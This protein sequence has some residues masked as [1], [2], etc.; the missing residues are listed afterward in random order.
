MSFEESCATLIPSLLATETSAHR[1][2]EENARKVFDLY[3]VDENKDVLQAPD[4]RRL[5]FDIMEASQWPLVVPDEN[6]DVIFEEMGQNEKNS[7]AWGDFKTFFLQDKPLHVLLEMA[8]KGLSKEELDLA[9]LVTMDP[10]AAI[11]DFS[12][13]RPL[14]QHALEKMLGDE[15]TS[16]Y[17]YFLD[18][19]SVSALCL[20]K[21]DS[22]QK[23]VTTEE[24]QIGDH[25]YNVKI[26]GFD[27]KKD[28]FPP[29]NRT[30]SG[31]SSQ[32]AQK[33]ADTYVMAKQWDERN[34]NIG[35]R[36][37]DLAKLV[38]E[39]WN[40]FDE[41]FKILEKVD[42]ASKATVEAVKAFDEK[43][44]ISQKFTDTAKDLDD[45]YEIRS[46]V[47]SHV[48]NIKS[49]E[50]VQQVSGKVSQMVK[51]SS[52]AIGQISKETQQR[53]NQTEQHATCETSEVGKQ[54]NEANP[55]SKQQKARE[56]DEGETGNEKTPAKSSE[57]LL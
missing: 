2:T 5:L 49:N 15:L 29:I 40:E 46:T 39:K 54:C 52:D 17:I 12:Y 38:R 50:N 18:A 28:V 48:D 23:D 33:L 6:L 44:Q 3:C 55:G 4:V 21:F 22:A 31:F 16:A 8:T 1:F 56:S 35:Q 13:E 53:M 24:V 9:R 37:A 42:H 32:V 7:I 25:L 51:N 14:F 27:V 45:K 26:E 57:P 10:V 30:V 34:L 47:Q 41:K 43:H 36:T 19:G 20:G 11:K